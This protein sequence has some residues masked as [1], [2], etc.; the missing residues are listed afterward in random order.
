MHTAMEAAKRVLQRRFRVLL[1][2]RDAYTR[3]SDHASALK[4]MQHDLRLLLQ[5]MSAWAR[6][7]YQRVPWSVLLLTTGAVIYFVAPVDLI[8]DALIGIGFV[9]DVAVV[10][11]VVRAVRKELDRFETWAERQSLSPGAA[12][13]VHSAS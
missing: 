1:L 7:S 2:V 12:S 6:R 10:S 9:D 3:M 11:M 8:P 13:D 5:M 4:G